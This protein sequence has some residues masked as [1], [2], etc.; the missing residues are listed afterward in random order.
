MPELNYNNERS[1]IRRKVLK[2]VQVTEKEEFVIDIVENGFVIQTE[3]ESK[4]TQYLK[5]K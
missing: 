2:P 4:V 5:V 1:Y 3:L